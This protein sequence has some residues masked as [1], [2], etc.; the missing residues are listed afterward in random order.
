MKLGLDRMRR[1]LSALGD[2]HVATPA[3][4]VAGTNGKGSTAALLASILGEAG[5]RVGLYT[6]PHLERPEERIRLG[7][8]DVGSGTLG[9][10]LVRV[11]GAA[12]SRLGGPPTY[13]E[14]MTAAAFLILAE[15]AMD[16]AVLEVGLGG[17]LDATNVVEPILSL[18]TDLSVEHRQQLGDSL[19]SIAREKAG[20]L[21]GG[22]PS[23]SAACRAEVRRALTVEAARV[24][25][26]LRFLEDEVRCASWRPQTLGAAVELAVVTPRRLHRLTLPLV[27]EHQ[28]RNAA[29]AVRAAEL[30]AGTGW[31]RVDAEAI[32]RGVRRVRWPG[33]FEIRTTPSGSIL[34]DAAHNP[35]AVAALVDELDGRRL[36]FELLFG[37]LDDKEVERMLPALASRAVHVT[38]TRPAGSRGRSPRSLLPLLPPATRVSVVEE[39]AVALESALGRRPDLLVVTGSIYLVGAVRGAADWH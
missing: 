37:V 7:D 13:F 23:L 15:E 27:G 6:S 34:L 28:V 29:L 8:R 22:R 9:R 3:V 32:R 31:D 5:Y 24:G 39:P 11:V 18:I 21:R 12:E 4:L 16:V 35:A 10:A 33:R 25:A 2:P 14:A 19:T 20:I 30:M 1:L 38:L 17:R 26:R 36:H